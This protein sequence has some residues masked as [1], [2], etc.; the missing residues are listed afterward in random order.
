MFFYNCLMPRPKTYLPDAL[1]DAALLQFWSVGYCA[2]SM[3]DLVRV[4]ASSRRALYLEFGGKRD[5]YLACF[6]RYRESVVDP[7]FARVE[8]RSANLSSIKDYF[9]FQ[10]AKAEAAGLPGPGCFVANAA[11]EAAPEDDAVQKIVCSHNE[12]LRLGFENS[13]RASAPR[14]TRAQ[15]EREK[16]LATALLVFA[17]GLWSLSRVTSNANDLRN[18]VNAMLTLIELETKK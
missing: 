2:T 6:E 15:A 13:I 18:A 10:I 17:N 8:L 16:N 14:R 11:T 1:V 9:F 3:D 7:A 4:T 12:R 5:L